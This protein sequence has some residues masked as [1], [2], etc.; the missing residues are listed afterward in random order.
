VVPVTVVIAVIT[1]KVRT[2]PLAVVVFVVI[3]VSVVVLV[4]ST[5]GDWVTFWFGVKEATS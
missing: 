2:P 3:V 5:L 1:N 4:M